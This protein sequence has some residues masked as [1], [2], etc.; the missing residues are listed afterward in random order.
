MARG[1]DSYCMC[2]D[3]DVLPVNSAVGSPRLLVCPLPGVCV[4]LYIYEQ[5]SELTHDTDI[6]GAATGAQNFR[7]SHMA[8]GGDTI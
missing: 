1:G 5:C 6:R 4:V 7:S 8:T 2:I 3:D